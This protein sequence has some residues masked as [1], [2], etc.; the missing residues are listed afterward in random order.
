MLA[1]ADMIGHNNPPEPIVTFKERLEARQKS[2]AAL[3]DVTEAN[4]DKYRDE[5]GLSL[6]LEQETEAQRVKE[7]KPILDAGKKVDETYNPVKAAAET[8]KLSLQRKLDAWIKARKAEADRIAAEK[9]EALRKAEEA[10]R[11]AEAAPVVEED[12][13]FL[14]ATAEPEPDLKALATEAKLAEMQAQAVTRVGSSG[15][16]FA[17][18]SVRSKPKVAKIIDAGALAAHYAKAS[19]GELLATLQKIANADIRKAGKAAIALPGVE[20]VEQD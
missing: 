14:A 6:T 5:I 3:G 13:P 9:A 10:K 7:K 4:A 2:A 18:Y 1:D 20:L 19:N 8:L 11:A 16:G 12:D 15:G 17:A